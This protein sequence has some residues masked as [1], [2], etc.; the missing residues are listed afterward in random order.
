[1]ASDHSTPH[2]ARIEAL[3]LRSM[4]RIFTHLRDSGVSTVAE[5]ADA[6]GLSR[7]T[8]KERLDDLAALQAVVEVDRITRRGQSSGRPASRFGINPS[9]GYVIGVELGKHDLR[10]LVCDVCGVVRRRLALPA[11]HRTPVAGRMADLAAQVDGLRAEHGDLGPLLAIGAAV[12]GTVTRA[13][14][15]GHS[16]IFPEWKGQN[17]LTAFGESF[18]V[19]VFI[20]NDLN[21]AAIAEYRH[22]A[23]QHATDIVL[24]LVW[25][26][27][28]AA[29]V[30]DGSLRV[31]RHGLAGELNRVRAHADQ[32][33]LRR[34]A[35]VPELLEAVDA[36][37]RGDAVALRAV[38]GFA[39]L[40]GAQIADMMLAIDPDLIVLY[41]RVVER[42]LVRRLVTAAVREATDAEIDTPV[43]PAA[44][45]DDAAVL[46]AVLLALDGVARR[47]FGAAAAPASRLLP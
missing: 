40:A 35:S 17:L 20:E 13:G 44:L 46:G 12:P 24:A 33:A 8:V 2:D 31:G 16:P 23:A 27:L 42:D 11:D 15:M 32:E 22:G 29:I 39:D 43:V 28:S 18:E 25:H 3:R 36:A 30:L 47:L 14:R 10:L 37:E 4:E 21:A 34:F 6:V 1:M 5:I 26:Q 38:R 19:P 45:G 7:P 9:L 41:G